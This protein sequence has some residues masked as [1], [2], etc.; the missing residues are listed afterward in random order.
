MLAPEDR[1]GGGGHSGREAWGQVWRQHNR[2]SWVLCKATVLRV[3]CLA[4]VCLRMF[5]TCVP[6]MDSQCLFIL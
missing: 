2:G 6:T 3:L 1:T 4:P 5:L